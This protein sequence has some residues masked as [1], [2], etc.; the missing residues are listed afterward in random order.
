MFRKLNMHTPRKASFEAWVTQGRVCLVALTCDRQQPNN[1]MNTFP[2]H[3]HPL[4][5]VMGVVC[6]LCVNFCLQ[7]FFGR[8]T[9]TPQGGD[10]E[11]RLLE[12]SALNVW[13]FGTHFYH[14]VLISSPGTY[15]FLLRNC[16]CAKKWTCCVQFES[17]SC[18]TLHIQVIRRDFSFVSVWVPSP[19]GRRVR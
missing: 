8:Q 7:S 16:I 5:L 1:L 14:P 15:S 9:V 11:A 2:T 18:W 10:L 17:N 6:Y 19:H 4:W 13:T 3:M 12:H